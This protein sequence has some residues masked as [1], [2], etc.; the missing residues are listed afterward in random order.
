MARIN[1][2]SK[3]LTRTLGHVLYLPTTKLFFQKVQNKIHYAVHGHTAAEY[4][5]VPHI[6]L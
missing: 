6:R 5:I 1:N 2:L 3:D 4:P